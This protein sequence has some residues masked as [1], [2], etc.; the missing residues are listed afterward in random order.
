DRL[1]HLALTEGALRRDAQALAAVVAE[2]HPL[3]P[4]HG[5]GDAAVAAAELV[6]AFAAEHVGSVAAAVDED[7]GLLSSGEGLGHR[8]LERSAEDDEATVLFL[9]KLLAQ[10]EDFYLW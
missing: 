6:T 4:V 5:E 7:D 2:E 3:P 10:V 1:Q 9:R 8:A